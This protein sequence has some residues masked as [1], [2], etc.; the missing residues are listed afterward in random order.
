LEDKPVEDYDHSKAIKSGH[1]RKPVEVEPGD[2]SMGDWHT[3][4]AS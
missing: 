3:N 2:N 4:I 1:W